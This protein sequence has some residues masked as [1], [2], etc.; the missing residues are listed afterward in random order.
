MR[1]W[2]DVI[3]NKKYR[4]NLIASVFGL[5]IVLS[6]FFYILA[7]TDSRHG[8]CIESGWMD[9][10]CRPVDLSVYIFTLTYTAAITGIISSFRD[11]STALL[12]IRT[13]LLLQTLRALTLLLVPLDPPQGI[14]PLNDPFLHATFYNGR[15]NLKDLFFSGHVATTLMFAFIIQRRG[16]KIFFITIAIVIGVLLVVQRVHYIV[17]ILAAPLFTWMAYRLAKKLFGNPLYAK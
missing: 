16:L 11:P 10:L 7:Y 2:K 14:I 3:E 9:N 17:D 13:Y 1:N 8:F 6:V 15:P 5:M 12:L 4:G